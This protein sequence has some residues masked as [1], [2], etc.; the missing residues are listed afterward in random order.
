[1]A[2]P[3]TTDYYAIL[4]VP[5]TADDSLIR[6][7]YKTLAKIRHPDKNLDNPQATAD[8]QLLLQAY[9]VLS[10]PIDRHNYDTQDYPRI[11]RQTTRS[12][13]TTSP[14]KATTS[15]TD[16]DPNPTLTELTARFD[17]LNATLFTLR[18]RHA[19]IA[20]LL[21]DTTAAIPALTIT[22][23]DLNAQLAA[24]TQES[25]EQRHQQ[26]EQETRHPERCVEVPDVD[27]PWM[28]AAL[29]EM[30]L[31]ATAIQAA[32][33]KALV[34]EA[35][36]EIVRVEAEWRAVG[37]LMMDEWAGDLLRGE[38]SGQ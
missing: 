1:M 13:S 32:G 5:Q 16:G 22:L 29:C 25:Q 31:E 19:N 17:T 28:Q 7:R 18:T 26:E 12:Q 3:A 21:A 2:S 35:W 38:E 11:R 24:Q 8:F 33:Y 30:A 15:D 4:G 14:S 10:N 37:G 27:D 34:D 9:S 36:E 23:A 6:S 20:Q